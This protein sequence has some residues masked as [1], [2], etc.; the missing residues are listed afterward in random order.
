M[1]ESWIRVV[2]DRA[3]RVD[4]GINIILCTDYQNAVEFVLRLSD[5]AKEALRRELDASSHSRG[6]I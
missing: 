2:A 3:L 1:S 4:R 5:D 6:S